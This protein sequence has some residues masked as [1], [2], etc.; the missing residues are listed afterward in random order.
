MTAKDKRRKA[1][2]ARKR[3][4]LARAWGNALTKGAT[5]LGDALKTKNVTTSGGSINPDLVDYDELDAGL[6]DRNF[7]ADWDAKP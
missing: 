6:D 7:Y 3:G 4:L 5:A 1:H 2:R